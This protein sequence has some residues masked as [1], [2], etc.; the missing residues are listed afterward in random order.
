MRPIFHTGNRRF[1]LVIPLMASA[2]SVSA[3]SLSYMN[4]DVSDDS[5]SGGVSDPRAL[6]MAQVTGMGR[7]S[8]AGRAGEMLDLDEAAHEAIAWHPAVI[9]AAGELSARGEEIAV[10]RAGYSPQISA[11]VGMSY[12]TRLTADW[13]PR[14]QFQASQMLFDFGKVRSAVDAARAGTKIGEG[15]ML[16]A[17]DGLIRDTGYAVIEL[18]RANALHQVAI[19][20]LAR[21]REIAELVGHRVRMGAA[22]RSDGLQVQ[23][24]VEAAQATLAQIE[25]ERGRWSSNLAYLLGRT[26]TLPPVSEDVPGWLMSA[27]R[28]GPPDWDM[29]PAVMV[30]QAQKERAEADL[31]RSKADQLPTVSIGGNGTV[32]VASP[33]AERR[34][35]YTL[36]ISVS[37][38]I[39]GGGITKAKVRSANYALA[40]A[41]AA[42]DR[43]RNDT[44]QRLSEA[45]QQIDSL[46]SLTSTLSSRQ[47]NMNETGKLYRLQYIEMGT[48]TLVDVLNAEQEFQ[49]VRFE[50]ANTKHDLR[51]LQ[52]DCLYNSG[53]TRS[54]F[55]LTGT[56][57]RGVT[58]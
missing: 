27:C 47:G 52:M 21:V 34:S 53:R 12:D 58:L 42:T 57:V 26:G 32:D 46:N 4:F 38:S 20:Q 29:V 11:G 36:G 31:R 50:A 17:I 51:R 35:A 48:R 1:W 7:A 28:Q 23:A 49:Q 30:A 15:E 5:V 54:A 14:P 9:E 3:Q 44:A 39:F 33:F 8:D 40:A 24:R 13:R 10:A 45:Q 41:E 18:Q 6:P 16:M 55:R 19:D 22:T 37:S 25:A 56:T 2:A 43:A